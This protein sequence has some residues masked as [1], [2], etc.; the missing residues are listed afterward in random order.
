MKKQL[1]TLLIG[2]ILT[3]ALRSASFGQMDKT[4]LFVGANLAR[5]VGKYNG[6]GVGGGLN[7]RLHY[8]LW[9]TL[10]LTAQLGLEYYKI[11]YY[12]YLPGYSYLGYGYNAITGFGFN[13]INYGPGYVYPVDTWG[14][15]LPITVAPRLYLPTLLKGLHADLNLGVDVAATRTMLTSL[16]VSP[17]VGYTLPLADGNFLDILIGYGTSLSRGSGVVGVSVA[18]GLPIHF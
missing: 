15:S 5:G 4:M 1:T 18:Y 3:V 9:P 10:A 13:T 16:L 14:I 12:D 17:G 2:G 8:S 11:K 6:L 7:A